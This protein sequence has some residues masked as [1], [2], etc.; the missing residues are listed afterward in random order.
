MVTIDEPPPFHMPFIQHIKTAQNQRFYREW[1]L[2]TVYTIDILAVI[3]KSR[4]YAEYSRDQLLVVYLISFTTA[5]HDICPYYH[6]QVHA[7]CIRNRRNSGIAG[8]WTF[9]GLARV[10][11]LLHIAG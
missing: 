5:F 10:L 6:P 4:S 8:S 11:D 2:Y 3:C 9:G 1:S 7:R